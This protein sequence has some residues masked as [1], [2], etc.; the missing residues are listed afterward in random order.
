MYTNIN[1]KLHKD[2][3]DKLK[4]YIS[5]KNITKIT[6]V[7]RT[8]VL[9]LLYKSETIDNDF[10]T[11]H[12]DSYN[13]TIV[14]DIDNDI[15]PEVKNNLNNLAIKNNMSYNAYLHMILGSHIYNNTDNKEV[16]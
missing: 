15:L 8:L 5:N 16:N 2:I 1:T 10:L 14:N 11:S 6:P 9:H 13:P 3:Y 4:S 7:I 12:Y